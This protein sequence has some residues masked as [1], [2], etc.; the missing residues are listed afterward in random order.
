MLSFPDSTISH[1]LAYV[2]QRGSPAWLVGGTVRDYFLGRVTHDLDIIV[3]E[4]GIRLARAIAGAFDAGFFILD[5][6]RDVGRAVLRSDEGRPLYVDVARLRAPDLVDDLAQ[7]DFTV[8]SIAVELQAAEAEPEVIDPFDG[9]GDVNRRLIRAVSE[10]AFDDDPL[11]MLRAVRLAAELGFSIETSTFRMVRRDAFL[12]PRVASERI[13]DELMR[14]VTVSG[15]WR[16]LRLLSALDLLPFALP[17]VAALVGIVQ[18]PPHYL[19]VFD[20]TRAVVA[21]MEG[22]IALLWPESQY[23]RPLTVA[24]DP[25]IMAAAGPWDELAG[26]LDSY[27]APLRSHLAQPLAAGHTRRDWLFWGALA[28]DWGK[29]VTPSRGPDGRIHFYGHEHESARLAAERAR[30]LSVAASEI[31]YL[32]RTVEYHMRPGHLADHYPPTRRALYHLFRDAGSLSPDI[33]MLALADQMAT[34]ASESPE[35]APSGAGAFAA[36]GWRW[37]DQL[38]VAGLIL[39]NYFSSG[40][41]S[42]DDRVLANPRP[43]LDGTRIMAEFDLSP[44]PLVGRL[45]AALREAQAIGEVTTVDEART[46]LSTHLDEIRTNETDD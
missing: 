40:E 46:W 31:D 26:L 32:S 25:V 37:E 28:H 4:G 21:H 5:Q 39:G 18:S 2:R 13:R 8:N 15:G 29:A 19:D 33:A 41:R 1:V 3:P 38:G 30:G 9:R 6:A 34:H 24:G 17:E 10:G 27:R 44:G 42:P 23:S 14:I 35:A 12:L 22:L 45:I 43:L 16:H 36:G 7:R 11:R 20:H